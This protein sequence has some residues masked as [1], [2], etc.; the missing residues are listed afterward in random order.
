MISH[1]QRRLT[2]LLVPSA[3]FGLAAIGASQDSEPSR[4][5]DSE[6]TSAEL[7]AHVRFLASDEMQGR[8]TGSEELNRAARYLA[9][10][11]KAFG[12]EPAGDDGSF[13]QEMHF[14]I[15]S[16]EAL[17]QL[18]TI[19]AQQVRT[20]ATYGEDF[21]VRRAGAS[22]AFEWIV[23]GEEDELPERKGSQ[24]ALCLHGMSYGKAGRWL[25]D[26]GAEDGAGYGLVVSFS[27]RPG[28]ATAQLPRA[29]R[30]KL[31]G[32]A[33]RDDTPAWIELAPAWEERVLAGEVANSPSWRAKRSS[34][35]PTTTTWE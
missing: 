23:V 11:F 9:A 6:I 13:L 28:T 17:P 32:D 4:L 31:A 25:A 29:S 35:R 7:E 15:E 19:D 8:A 14:E 1:A 30:P 26:H 24:V 12:L 3:L 10:E 16:Y 21:R 5:R 27:S 34:S 33:K 18:A 20:D 2:V 22:G